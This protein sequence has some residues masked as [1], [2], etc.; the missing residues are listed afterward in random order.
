[1]NNRYLL[2]LSIV[3]IFAI[4]LSIFSVSIK[5]IEKLYSFFETYTSLPIVDF[6]INFNFLYLSGLIFVLYR[7][8]RKAAI[9]QEELEDVINSITPYVLIVADQERN[10]IM[11]SSS[12]KRMYGYEVNEVINQKTDL[13]YSDMPSNP[14]HN[15]EIL[16]ILGKEGFYAGFAEGKK[17]DGKT[18]LLEII[19][20]NLRGRGGSVSLLKD[21]TQRKH[22]EDEL[23][24][25]DWAIESSINGIGIATLEGHLTYVNQSFLKMWG[26]DEKEVL[27]KHL[28]K[29]CQKEDEVVEAIKDEGWIGEMKARRKDGSLFDVSFSASMVKDKN[30]N[31][32][33][34]M[35]SFI[36]ITK[37]KQAEEALKSSETRFRTLIQKSADGVLVTDKKGTVRFV[38]PS[39]ESL[40]GRKEKELIGEIFGFPLVTGETAGLDIPHDDKEPTIVDM[41][42]VET[43]WEGEG[44]YLL[45]LRD[46]TARKRYEESLIKTTEELKRLD[47]IKS[48]FIS[49][50][51]HELR[52]PLASIKN[53]VD[54]ILSRKTGEITDAQEKFLSMAQRNVNRLSALI[55]D[56]LDI[57]R[58]ESGK[59][60]LNY[61]EVD[62]KNIIENVINTF[63]SLANEKSISLKMNIAPDLPSIYVDASRIEQVLIN[64]V[65]NAIKF[66]P[67][68]G[69]IAVGV[70]QV[71]GVPDMPEDM[72]GFVEISVT[73]TGT[74][75]PEEHVK[76][77]FEKFYQVESSLSVKKQ[78]GTGLGLAIS[79]GIVNALG[80]KIQC[81]SKEGVGSTFSFTLPIIGREKLFYYSLKNEISK[82]RQ[83]HLPLSVLIIKLEDFA[84]V[85]EVYGIKECE[86]VLELVKEKIEKKVLRFIDKINVSRYNGE[87]IVLIIMPDII[88]SGAQAAKERLTPYITGIEIAV[89]ESKYSCSFVSGVATYP[90]DAKS[91]EELLVFAMERL[92]KKG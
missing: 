28:L 59:I 47:Q 88:C 79:K 70:H 69:T 32:I 15:N 37:R 34:M 16:D 41:R 24:I 56:L 29:F 80:G 10:I 7:C 78:P 87:I 62:I 3:L 40:F 38:N 68:R 13:L 27:G 72:S 36:D 71:E 86:R 4:T 31:P 23:R 84:H 46:A 26:Y 64:L 43:E 55:N 25:K 89:G 73:D 45:S 74:G 44:A 21:I 20:G 35:A 57:S 2:Y 66:T 61:T 67:A 51:S 30:N 1:M 75:I 14:E 53:A 85:K 17:K 60:Q 76:H 50:A 33:C 77:L 58:I 52:T 22:I 82:A 12:L 83:Y 48:D 81:K 91:A 63:R 39:A 6:L 19:T 8:W 5:F 42:V 9:K 54:I 18:I 92:E 49:T 90:D 11:C 65:N